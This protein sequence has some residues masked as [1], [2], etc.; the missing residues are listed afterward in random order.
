MPDLQI[1]A[2]RASPFDSRHHVEGDPENALVLFASEQLRHENVGPSEK[3]DDAVL[4]G[5]VVLRKD[6]GPG[7]RLEA[8]D[9]TLLSGHVRLRPTRIEEESFIGSPDL[10]LPQLRDL[11]LLGSWDPVS[12]PSRQLPAEPL[13]I[14]SC[15]RFHAEG[16]LYSNPSRP[17]GGCRRR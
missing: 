17:P 7:R 5:E 11:Q 13:R 6:P 14:S 8:R 16:L 2:R 12:K 3:L 1:S 10:G 9:H 15:H 4:T